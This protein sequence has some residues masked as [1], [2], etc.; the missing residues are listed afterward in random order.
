MADA[1]TGA[2]TRTRRAIVA[3]AL[4]VLAKNQGASLSDVA[5]AAQV[6][7]TT[8]HRYFAERSDLIAAI[9]EETI[10]QVI[11]AAERARLDRGPAPEALARLCREY[12]ELGSVL[13]VLFTG[14]VEIPDED[15]ARHE[16]DPGHGLA[17]AIA[18]GR[19]EGTIAADLT[20]GWIEQ[21][22][23]ALLYTAWNYAREQDIPRQEALDLCIRSLLKTIAA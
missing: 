13:T 2:H 20:D 1:E 7:R 12:F 18:R 9:A 19:D 22:I 8:V 3:A 15:W 23:W 6:S 14:T 16:A 5:T 10:R 17:E 21:L 4:D 11:A